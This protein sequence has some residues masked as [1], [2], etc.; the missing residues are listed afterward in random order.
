MNV[1]MSPGI[2]SFR[3]PLSSIGI[4]ASRREESKTPFKA[5]L[6]M[7]SIKCLWTLLSMKTSSCSWIGIS[8]WNGSDVTVS[9]IIRS[10]RMY[11]TWMR[12]MQEEGCWQ[13]RGGTKLQAQENTLIMKSTLEIE[14]MR[15]WRYKRIMW[16]QREKQR[17][18]CRCW[19]SNSWK[20]KSCTDERRS[21]SRN[22]HNRRCNMHRL[23]KLCPYSLW[24]HP[25]AGME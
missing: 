13:R 17:R 19:S 5:Q 24:P 7:Q 6:G 22:R 10:R 15:W 12:Q 4:M 11:H 3:M 8:R 18:S 20:N 21:C 1:A 25:V 2:T 16:R 9:T 14:A 23:M